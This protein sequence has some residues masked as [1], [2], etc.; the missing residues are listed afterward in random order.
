[1][2]SENCTSTKN[3]VL[4]GYTAIT[5]ES[6]DEPVEGALELTGNALPNQ[7]LAG[8]TF[9]N[10]NAKSKQTGTMAVQSI[11]S[12]SAAVYSST[13]IAFTWQN[14]A[15]GP[16]SEVIIVGKTGSYPTSIT[17]GTRY[18]KGS[19]SNSTA[20]GTSSA[21]VSG[22]SGGTTYYFRALS[23]TT[24]DSG[25]WVHANTY[26]AT[27]VTTK[28]MQ[29]FKASGTFTVPTGVRNVDIFCVGGGGSGARGESVPIGLADNT[30]Y[31]GSGGGAGGFTSTGKNIAV[32]PGESL[33]ITVGDG[34]TAISS[35]LGADGGAS[36]VTRSSTVLKSANGG[37]G[38]EKTT[39]AGKGGSGGS[40]GG[41]GAFVGKSSGDTIS[42]AATSGGANGASSSGTGQGS[43]TKAFEDSS[44]T[45]F[46]GAGGGGGMRKTN[47]SVQLN[48]ASGGAGGGGRGGNYAEGD[49]RGLP[50]ATNTG[51]G[52]GGGCGAWDL[53][54]FGGNGGSGI[55]IIRWGY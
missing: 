16:F 30:N 8:S 26:T 50:G 32:T 6:G 38:A 42:G 43:T 29:T 1:M 41:R 49:M 46:S 10:A 31:Y 12:F 22:F 39:V 27:V 37:K 34:G 44:G 52:G 21:T 36:L 25:E 24:K 51:G 15:K 3:E 18:Y 33:G 5:S 53:G 17:D 2:G 19:G 28:G 47:N 35:Y 40:G 13:A 48:G 9:Y 14:P 4:K 55:V 45:Q 11:L 20:S 23:Y 54:D 7:V